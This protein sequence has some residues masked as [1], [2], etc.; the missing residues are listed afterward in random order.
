MIVGLI[1]AGGEGRRMGGAKAMRLLAGAPLIEYVA[2][3]FGDVQAM[4][5]VGD[6]E[7]AGALSAG[8]L[9]D[10]SDVARGPLAGILAGLEWARDMGADW[11]A[12]APCDAPMLPNDLVTRLHNAARNGVAACAQTPSGFEPLISIWRSDV[13]HMLRAALADGAHPPVHTFMR[14]LNAGCVTLSADEVMNIN[15]PDDLQRAE[16]LLARR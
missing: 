16:A 15:T 9:H 4:A 1:L 8:L 10:P 11:L 13:A 5:V 12:V 14:G 3:A 2:H 6:A 7:A